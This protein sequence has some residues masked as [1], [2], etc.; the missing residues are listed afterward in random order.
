MKYSPWYHTAPHLL[1]FIE[2]I[3]RVPFDNK[4]DLLYDCLQTMIGIDNGSRDFSW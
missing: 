2:Y 4:N 3:I 1:T